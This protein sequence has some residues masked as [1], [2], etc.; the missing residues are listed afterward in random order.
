MSIIGTGTLAGSLGPAMGRGGYHVVYGSRKPGRES[1]RELVVQT[2]NNSTATTPR[3]A[4]AKTDIIVLAVPAEVVIEVTSKLGNLDGKVVVDVSVGKKR[5]ASDGYLELIPGKTNSERLQSQYPRAR[6][7]RV[8]LPSIASFEDPLSSGTPPTILIAGNDPV[9]RG[10]VAQ[11]IFDLG[12]NPWDAGPIRFSQVFDAINVMGLIPAQQGRHEAYELRLMPTA[13]LSCFL[14]M[15]EMFG[16]DRPKDLD[17]LVD[18]PRRE[19]VI[20]CEVWMRSPRTQ[21]V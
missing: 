19:P 15:S 2:G 5:V 8:N 12:L 20:P 16:F 13:P 1:V 6:I 14:D 21:W 11:V 17:S 7:V 9:A 10:A 4:A 18:F 3:E